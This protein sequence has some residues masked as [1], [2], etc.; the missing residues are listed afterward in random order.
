M[1]RYSSGWLVI[2]RDVLF[3]VISAGSS[4]FLWL[5]KQSARHWPITYGRVEFGKSI[6][7]NDHWRSDIYYSYKVGDEFY[8]GILSLP[9]QNELHADEQIVEWKQKNLVVRFSPKNSAIS[10]VRIEDQFVFSTKD[11]PLLNSRIGK[12]N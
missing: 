6:D 3:L 1:S 11:Y 12:D 9:A 5:R 10:V 4:I 8:S 7:E 2:L